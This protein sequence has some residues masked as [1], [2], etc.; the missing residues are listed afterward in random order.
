VTIFFSDIK[1][2]TN[3]SESISPKDLVNHL[4]EYLTELSEII[5]KERGT[6]DKYIGDSIMAFWNAPYML[7]EHA[8]AACNAALNC[9]KR[10]NELERKWK[11][12]N[13]PVLQSRIGI[14]TGS[15]IVGN[16]GS[17]K[18]MNYT[19]IGDSVN[20]ASRLEGIC[21]YYGVRIIISE[22]TYNHI[23]FYFVTRKLD[24]VVVKGKK[25]PILIFELIDFKGQADNNKLQFIDLYETGLKSYFAKDWDNAA[26]HFKKAYSMNNQDDAS[27]NLYKRAMLYKQKP[28]LDDWDGSYIYDK[29]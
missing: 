13:L 3:I 27:K 16:M 23:K 7:E 2:F 14:N 20:V 28:P 24:K 10:L 19:V 18:R 21:K 11:D 4:G 9:Q 12:S 8:L 17:E 29:K 22:S 25:E 6:V 1:D 5:A 26:L 15:V